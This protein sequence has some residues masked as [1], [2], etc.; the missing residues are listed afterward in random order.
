MA[1]V[2]CILTAWLLLAGTLPAQNVEKD[3]LKDYAVKIQGRHAYG[4]YMKDVKIGWTVLDTKLAKH[5]GKEVLLSSEE[6]MLEVKRDREGFKVH[7]KSSTTYSLEGPGDVL[8][9]ED[10][11][12]ENGK[13]KLLQGE[14]RGDS[15]VVS[16]RGKEDSRKLPPPKRTLRMARKFDDWLRSNPAKGDTFEAYTISLED[17]DIDTK[18]VNAFQNKKTLA[19]GGVQTDVYRVLVRSKGAVSDMEMRSDGT[20][21]RGVIG[22]FL[23]VRSEPE[24]TAKKVEAA[25][26]DLLAAASIPADKDLGDVHRVEALTLEVHGL[27]DYPLPTSHR[28]VLKPGDEKGVGVLELKRDFKPEKA[29]PL[30][31]A[32]RKKMLEATPTIQSEAAKVREL[33]KEIVGDETDTHKKAR[34]IKSWVFR[35]LKKSFNDNATTTLDVLENLAGDCTEHALLFVSLARA[36][37]LPAREVGGVGYYNNGKPLFGWHAWSEYHDGHQWVSIDPTWN[38]DRVDATHIKFSDSAEDMAWINV[39]GKVKFKVVNVERRK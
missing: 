3:S 30:A 1:R 4:V 26:I 38:Q 6:L 15:F 5:D 34:L 24:A 36:S 27:G 14:R 35:K 16:R 20:P 8:K 19:L 28:Q 33:A 11:K 21:L 18:E 9:L 17:A 32:E 7:S 2:H 39:L 13:E 12:K 23:E 29:A 10:W 37:G 22:G 31:D 25:N